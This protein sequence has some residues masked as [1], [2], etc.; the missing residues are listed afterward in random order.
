[1]KEK[2]FTAIS[3]VLIFFPFTIFSDTMESVG[4][5]VTCG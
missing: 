3:T 1:M 5:G 2:L 4:I